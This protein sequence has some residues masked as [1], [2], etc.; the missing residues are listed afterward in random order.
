MIIGIT[1]TIGSGK[2]TVVDY[3]VNKKGFKHFAVSDNFLANE[4]IRRGQ[5]P[6]R[7]ARRN[8][9]NEY[10]AKGPTK[11]QEEL[12]KLALP[13]IEAKENVVIEPQYTVGEV[14]FIQSKG[15][16]V[17]AVDAE[18]KLRYERIQGRASEKDKVTF[19]E[20]SAQEDEEL[21]STDPNKNNITTS[22]K[23]ADFLFQNNGSQEELFKQ[24]EAALGKIK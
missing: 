6:D 21:R 24:I 8:I 2:G 5:K 10:R 9:A 4:A 11:L 13:V 17:F 1:G 23:K 15:G 14:E 22:I 12:W 18:R 19:E 20:F 3:L 7:V 16:V